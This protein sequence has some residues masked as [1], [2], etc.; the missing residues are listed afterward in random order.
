MSELHNGMLN[1]MYGKQESDEVFTKRIHHLMKLKEQGHPVIY[2]RD[3]FNRVRIKHG[4]KWWLMSE[5]C[6]HIPSLRVKGVDE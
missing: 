4:N 1:R 3:S 2:Y 5:L 6:K